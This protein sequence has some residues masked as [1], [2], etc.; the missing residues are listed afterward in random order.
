MCLV[1]K[2]VGSTNSSRQQQEAI[3]VGAGLAGGAVVQCQVLAG[4]CSPLCF[5]GFKAI[6]QWCQSLLVHR[7]YVQEIHVEPLVQLTKACDTEIQHTVLCAVQR[8][9]TLCC[10]LCAMM[11]TLS[12]VLT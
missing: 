1:S 12:T 4:N 3:D 6:K 5:N 7:L 11:A 9:S 10:A 8:Y 2:V